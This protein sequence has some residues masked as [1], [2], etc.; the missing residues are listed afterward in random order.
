MV[1]RFLTQY[2]VSG[3]TEPRTQKSYSVAVLC[4]DG[5]KEIV[6]RRE[7][8]RVYVEEIYGVLAEWGDQLP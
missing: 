5:R 4:S 6:G 2:M 7:N 8:C 3:V 1:S